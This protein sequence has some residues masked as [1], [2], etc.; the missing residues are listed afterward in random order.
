MY[1]EVIPSRLFRADAGI[2]T[3]SSDQPLSPGQLVTIPIGKSTALGLVLRKVTKLSFDPKKLKPITTILDFPPLPPTPPSR[4]H[5]ALRLL[6]FASTYDPQLNS[7]SQANWS[8]S[9][10]S[11]SYSSSANWS[12]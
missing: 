9:Q 4:H 1:Y 12:R 8:W 2:L 3:Y 6:S 10:T 5:L 11:P 7:P